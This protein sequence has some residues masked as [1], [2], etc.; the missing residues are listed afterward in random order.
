MKARLAVCV[1]LVAIAFSPWRVH[2]EDV[3]IS[4]LTYA[5]PV[6]DVGV[7]S[8]APD[9]NLAHSETIS[10]WADPNSGVESYG[11][12]KFRYPLLPVDSTSAEAFLYA[13]G[14]HSSPSEGGDLL[15]RAVPAQ[16]NWDEE[17]VNW[18]TRP[19]IG[20]GSSV[21]VV[22][23]TREGGLYGWDVSAYFD[24]R[25]SGQEVTLAT[26]PDGPSPSGST[27][28]FYAAE[29]YLETGGGLNGPREIPRENPKLAIGVNTTTSAFYGQ[30]CTTCHTDVDI[31]DATKATVD[32]QI[33][34]M[35]WGDG[36][37]PAASSTTGCGVALRGA[38]N[39]GFPDVCNEV[40]EPLKSYVWNDVCQ[41]FRDMAAAQAAAGP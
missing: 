31:C 30:Y 36:Q 35:V 38:A 19:Q 15:I 9:V 40:I 13:L 20:Q 14:W 41:P 37:N 33:P 25:Q 34:H 28:Y 27:A 11:L 4:Y 29:A 5:T 2:A 12:F 1:P 18:Y 8:S 24:E 26:V 22:K 16:S 32:L 39:P 10:T 3:P 6:E 17:T 21:A 23:V 7:D